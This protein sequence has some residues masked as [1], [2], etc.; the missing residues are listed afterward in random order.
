MAGIMQ[1]IFSMRST[2]A[3]LGFSIISTISD[4]IGEILSRSTIEIILSNLID[5]S[6][7]PSWLPKLT[8][9][10]IKFLSHT[11]FYPSIFSLLK[12]K[13]IGGSSK[14]LELCCI[15]INTILSTHGSKEYF[16]IAFEGSLIV[17]SSLEYVLEKGLENGHL[18]TKTVSKE[19]YSIYYQNWPDKAKIFRGRLSPEISKRLPTE[20]FIKQQS[21]SVVPTK[22]IASLLKQRVS[23]TKPTTSLLK[24]MIPK[25]KQIITTPEP[26]NSSLKQTIPKLKQIPTTSKNLTKTPTSTTINPSTKTTHLFKPPVLLRSTSTSSIMSAPATTRSHELKMQSNVSVRQTHSEYNLQ[27]SIAAKNLLNKLKNPDTNTKILGIQILIERLKETPYYSTKK[28]PLPTNVP[29][30]IDLLP[31]L[32]DFLSRKNLKT[33]VYEKLMSWD[34]IAGIFVRTLSIR[35]YCPTL[36]IADEQ[37]KC[38]NLNDKDSKMFNLY[39]QG[40]KRV[41]M[42]LKRNDSLLAFHLLSILKSVMSADQKVLDASV[43]LDL[44][45]NALYQPSLEL[46]LLKWMN[47]LIQDYVGL[48]Q[49]EDE[50]VLKEGSAWLTTESDDASAEQWFESPTN[51]QTYT[52]FVI[53]Q[54]LV[55]QE[56]DNKF[57]LLCSMLRSLKM[58]NVKVFESRM[59]TLDDHQVEQI[60]NILSSNKSYFEEENE[61]ILPEQHSTQKRKRE[62]LSLEFSVEAAGDNDEEEERNRKNIKLE[63]SPVSPSVK[64]LEQE[65]FENEAILPEQHSNQKR[66]RES[67]SLE[68]SVGAAG[69]NDEEEERNR[70]NIK[71]EHSPVS[72]GVKPLELGPFE[73]DSFMADPFK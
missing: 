37:K 8:E 38:Q 44:R 42:F 27:S 15:A 19:I 20:D 25:S 59:K 58:G 14:H 62:S 43:K 55:T 40:L 50:E 61:V 34:C 57:G 7:V 17:S 21:T 53:E 28:S 47:E 13:I 56:E 22:K 71:L 45:L 63:H 10:T 65:S 26:T 35:N 67:L 73:F 6:K 29:K 60:T 18:R 5:R 24:Q 31:L 72:P 23:S 11:K 70:K 51:I 30:K 66:K 9:T 12:K 36:I 39:S 33:K 69:D 68:F 49:D 52:E 54:L 46:G 64:P 48:P 2:V 1:S 32:M 41:K 3:L 16:Q 4:T